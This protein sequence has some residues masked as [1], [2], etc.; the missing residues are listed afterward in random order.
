MDRDHAGTETGTAWD[1]PL[2]ASKTT[3]RSSGEAAHRMRRKLDEGTQDPDAPTL[4]ACALRLPGPQRRRRCN[5]ARHVH[6]RGRHGR[7]RHQ[8][9]SLLDSRLHTAAPRPA[10]GS[11]RVRGRVVARS[12]CCRVRSTARRSQQRLRTPTWRT[13]ATRP[14]GL[15]R[16]LEGALHVL[17]PRASAAWK[18]R[19]PPRPGPMDA[20]PCVALHD[21]A[22]RSSTEV[23]H[24]SRGA[25][26]AAM[27]PRA[28]LRSEDQ[29]DLVGRAQA[30]ADSRHELRLVGRTMHA[31]VD[32]FGRRGGIA[33]QQR[34][35]GADRRPPGDRA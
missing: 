2:L 18:E 24:A 8:G 6:D 16:G 21:H 26:V 3:R 20:R 27:T 28:G 10:D 1:A 5:R 29:M 9:S 34:H 15:R 19:V 22:R 14:S 11:A 12:V 33:D 13:K 32:P 4:G 31:H 25:P 23:R 7:A 17:V 35:E 30:S